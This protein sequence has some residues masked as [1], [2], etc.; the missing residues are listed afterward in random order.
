L[1]AGI[2]DSRCRRFF[3]SSSPWRTL[4]VETSRLGRR[5]ESNTSALMHGVMASSAKRNQVLFRI[6]T[7]LAAKLL[8]M[9][10]EV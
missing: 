6:I 1:S 8:V 9:D 10:F 3:L 7:G 5:T 4:R 2:V